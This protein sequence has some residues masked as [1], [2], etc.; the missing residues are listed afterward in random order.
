LSKKNFKVFI[1]LVIIGVSIYSS[2]NMVMNSLIHSRKEIE[3]PN[4]V[5]KSLYD[6]LDEL[7]NTGFGLIKNDE[8]PD[9]NIPAGTIL[10]Q[11]PPAGMLVREGKTIKV[12]ISQGG[13]TVYVPNLIGQT[14]R[15]ADIALR[16][17]TLVMGEVERRFSTTI[18]KDY[19]I[20]QDIKAGQKVDKDS[21]VNIVVSEG[22]PPEGI[23]LLPN[24][25]NQ[26]IE[27]AKI[28]AL[29]NNVTLDIKT[30]INQDIENNTIVNQ[31]PQNDTDITNTKY[32]TLTVSTNETNLQ[33]L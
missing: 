27:E 33:N 7:S 20:A 26:N 28:W 12:T 8:E 1:A 23:I 6:A 11:N 17:S 2:F 13:E 5:G 31:Y 10:R 25:V 24:F 30:E 19:V 3:I 14:I 32:V 18:E 4:L 15:S 16:H 22:V 29:E 21:V 9:Q